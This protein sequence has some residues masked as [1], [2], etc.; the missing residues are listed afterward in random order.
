M[1]EGSQT[2]ITVKKHDGT[3]VRMTLAEF[4]A[5]RAS[6][7]GTM[8][9]EQSAV[10]DEQLA[11]NK[12]QPTNSNQ[13]TT[14]NQES[15]TN[16]QESTI[17][18]QQTTQNDQK[19]EE[20]GP[21][22]A[23]ALET[24]HE[25]AT[26]TPVPDAFINEARAAWASEDHKSL[27]D[28]EVGEHELKIK[29]SQSS[30]VPSRDAALLHAVMMG[31]PFAIPEEVKGRLQS[32]IESRVKD[33]RSDDDV[34]TY[35]TRPVGDGG[36]GLSP[37]QAATLLETIL[38]TLNLEPSE[39]SEAVQPEAT[40]APAPEPAENP[41]Q[42]K[43]PVFSYDVPGRD[44]IPW[45]PRFATAPEK[46]STYSVPATHDGKPML[47]DVQPPSSVPRTM[48]PV[49][50][51]RACTLTDLRRLGGHAEQ[52]AAAMI[53]KFMVLRDESFVLYLDAV[54]AFR[55]SPLFRSYQ[56]HL[57]TS[58]NEGISLET[59][60]EYDEQGMTMEDVTAIVNIMKAVGY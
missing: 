30:A 35:G 24:P 41:K 25:L 34:L 21:D 59:A 27:L 29:P 15:T 9:S 32:L 39:H 53:D 48:G 46:Q 7:Q 37:E 49:D 36:L 20:N 2:M 33:V 40:E 42:E 52:M 31:L 11:T 58:L 60:L 56:E 1:S 38:D 4:K 16:N 55:Q 51:F 17:N 50:E 28:E 23:I 45:Q 13:Q 3:V 14:N 22:S 18:N 57:L 6:Q 47:Q 19:E 43:K 8:G 10:S 5:Y 26:T 44:E 12:Q 54:D